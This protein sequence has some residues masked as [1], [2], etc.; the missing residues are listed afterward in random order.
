MT[1]YFKVYIKIKEIDLSFVYFEENSFPYVSG[2]GDNRKY[3]ECYSKECWI[4]I[5]I[6]SEVGMKDNL[7]MHYFSPSCIHRM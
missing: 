2:T 6:I 5:G 3:E 4:N 1:K 7:E